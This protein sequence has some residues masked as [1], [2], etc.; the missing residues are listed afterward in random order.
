[1]I[2]VML[3]SRFLPLDNGTTLDLTAEKDG[4]LEDDDVMMLPLCVPTS[5]LT[6]LVS[7]SISNG[8]RI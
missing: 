1:M 2:E 5:C 8:F 6:R 7:T 3:A 4:E